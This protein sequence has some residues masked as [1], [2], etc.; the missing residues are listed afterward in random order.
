VVPAV[1]VQDTDTP[2]YHI[3]PAIFVD[4]AATGTVRIGAKAGS[5]I[6]PEV[7]KLFQQCH[8]QMYN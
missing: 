5:V 2:F 8:S 4:E 1:A 7:S 6:G 3:G